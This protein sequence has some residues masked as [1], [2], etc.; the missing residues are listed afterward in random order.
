MTRMREADPQ[1]RVCVGCAAEWYS[2]AHCSREQAYCEICGSP[3]LETFATVV[4]A[5]RSQASGR[6]HLASRGR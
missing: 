5:I 4:A 6:R 1:L 2:G 3:L